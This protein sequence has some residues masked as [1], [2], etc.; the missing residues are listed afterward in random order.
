MTKKQAFRLLIFLIPLPVF[1]SQCFSSSSKQDEPRGELYAGAATCA[2]CHKNVYNSYL[3]TAHF[4]ASGPATDS[5]L[6]GNFNKGANELIFNP[7]LKVVMEKRDSGFYQTSYSN[8]KVEQSQRFD[9]VFGAVKGQSY[10]YWLANELFQL[11]VSYVKNSNSW[12]NSPGYDPKRVAFERAI[13]TRCLD[14]HLSYAKPAPAQLPGF[15]DNEEGFEKQSLVF[16]VDCE[17]CHGPAAQHVKFQTDNP[18]EKKAKYIT[19]FS[20]LSREQ[21]INI[22]AI[23]HSGSAS[24]LLKPTFSFK[25]GDTLSKYLEAH[26]TTSQTDYTHIDVHGNQKA[27]LE[28]S[29]CFISSQLDCSTC[30]NTHV[31][32]RGKLTLF[33]AKCMTCH[34]SDSHIQCK[35]TGTLNASMLTNNCISCHMPAFTSKTIIAGQSP[36]LIHTHHIGVYPEE[37]QKIMAYIKTTIKK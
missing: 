15:Y 12:I 5:T 4:K 21:K 26:K 29:K 31:N 22:C 28:S 20:S 14:C 34:N 3:H 6:Q 25:P 10:A 11:P 7:H 19:T 18:A 16:S 13:G 30:H 23:C 37:T 17:R 9:I 32:D 1:L 27:L 35:L 36:T 2:G 33:A 8:G 24:R